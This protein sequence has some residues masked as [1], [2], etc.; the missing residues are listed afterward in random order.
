MRKTQ[1][2]AEGKEIT[3][4]T[5]LTALNGEED[6]SKERAVD[7][8]YLEFSKCFSHVFHYTFQTNEVRT[9]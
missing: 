6:S 2:F 7:V 9:A 3:Q 5:E 8:F 1:Y 4:V